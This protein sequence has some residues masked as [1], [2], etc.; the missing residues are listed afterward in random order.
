MYVDSNRVHTW[1]HAPLKIALV[2]KRINVVPSNVSVFQIY[3]AISFADV[4]V[5][6]AAR[7]K[8]VLVMQPV[9]NVIWTIVCPLESMMRIAVIEIYRKEKKSIW[10]LPSLKLKAQVGA[11]VPV[12]GIDRYI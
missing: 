10:P 12:N 7:R 4:D 6:P 8:P 9:E 11:V 3:V 5:N 1:V 2:F